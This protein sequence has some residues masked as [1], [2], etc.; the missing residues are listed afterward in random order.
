[1]GQRCGQNPRFRSMGLATHQALGDTKDRELKKKA[2]LVRMSAVRTSSSYLATGKHERVHNEKKGRALFLVSGEQGDRSARQPGKQKE[3][4]FSAEKRRLP[5]SLLTNALLA[6][7][8]SRAGTK[9]AASMSVGNQ[10]SFN[11]LCTATCSGDKIL[12]GPLISQRN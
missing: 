7:H 6:V 11:L 1:L 10:A 8:R 12:G 5:R 4:E 2:E 3:R 9:V